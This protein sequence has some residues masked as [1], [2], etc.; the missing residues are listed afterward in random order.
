MFFEYYTIKIQILKPFQTLNSPR[1]KKII[2]TWDEWAEK[3]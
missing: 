3:F 2:K 1:L